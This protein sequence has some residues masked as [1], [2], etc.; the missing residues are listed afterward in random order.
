MKSVNINEFGIA[1]NYFIRCGSNQETANN[2]ALALIYSC[3][4]Q[5][6]S[7]MKVITDL[8]NNKITL[9]DLTYYY[10]YSQQLN[11][12]ANKSV[13]RNSTESFRTTYIRS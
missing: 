10:N 8:K 1:K 12:D 6:L 3:K 9:N 7:V 13:A 5:N 4:K 2:Y 11:F